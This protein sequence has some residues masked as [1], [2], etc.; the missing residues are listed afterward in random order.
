MLRAVFSEPVPCGV[1]FGSIFPCQMLIILQAGVCS[2]CFC[3]FSW[4]PVSRPA[5]EF[6]FLHTAGCTL[7]ATYKRGKEEG[8]RETQIFPF[9]LDFKAWH[10]GGK[11]LLHVTSAALGD[12]GD[13]QP[14]LGP[15]FRVETIEQGG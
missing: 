11:W 7:S 8:G 6:L 9:F 3:A 12:A 2:S 1:R 5:L 14:E 4:S 15:C 10:M 13:P